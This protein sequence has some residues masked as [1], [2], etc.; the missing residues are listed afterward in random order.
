MGWNHFKTI[1]NG[2][3]AKHCSAASVPEINIKEST[4]ERENKFGDT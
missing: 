2:K 3:C 1:V 4:L